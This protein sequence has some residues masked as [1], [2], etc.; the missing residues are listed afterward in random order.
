MRSAFK[1]I[2]LLAA[3]VLG[4]PSAFA[5]TAF[6]NFGP[7]LATGPGFVIASGEQGEFGERTSGLQFTAGATGLLY[8][9]ALVL[10]AKNGGRPNDGLRLTLYTDAGDLPGTALESIILN[11]ICYVDFDCPTGELVSAQATGTTLLE[12]GEVYWLLASSDFVAGDFAW[13]LTTENQPSLVYID[14]GIT[15]TFEFEFPP[16]L[17]VQVTPEMPPS[18]PEPASLLLLGMAA[19]ALSFRRIS[20]AR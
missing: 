13:Y 10:S 9:F 6:D 15:G 11:D 7:D 16:G 14:N 20:S 3:A 8:Q 2:C 18:V 5:I 17:R 4:V 19:A 12:E 1:F